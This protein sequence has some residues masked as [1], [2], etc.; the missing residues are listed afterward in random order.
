[1]NIFRLYQCLSEHE[2]R[3]L[4]NLIQKNDVVVSTDMTVKDWINAVQPS[5]RLEKCLREFY[6][7]K[8][9][10]EISAHD[11]AKN[12]GVGLKTYKEFAKLIGEI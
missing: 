8:K 11:F 9:V 2:K 4:K 3:E 5:T 1:M 7:D 6:S 10:S 12:R